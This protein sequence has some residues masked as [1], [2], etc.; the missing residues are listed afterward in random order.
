MLWWA[1]RMPPI[2]SAGPETYR[3]QLN[4]EIAS[5]TERHIAVLVDDRALE[6]DHLLFA[7]PV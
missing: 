3:E 1:A 5:S 4:G 6:H 7:Y 2:T